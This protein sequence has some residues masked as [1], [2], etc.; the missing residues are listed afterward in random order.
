MRATTA[1]QLVLSVAALLACARA[2]IFSGFTVARQF[3]FL[4]KFCFT[5]QP[6]LA[7]LA[8]VRV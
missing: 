5:W 7:E 1:W 4:G 6:T 3:E 8:G 2:S